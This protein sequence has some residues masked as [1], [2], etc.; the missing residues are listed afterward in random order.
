MDDAEFEHVSVST[1]ILRS[2]SKAIDFMVDRAWFDVVSLLAAITLPG[3]A[4]EP[5]K[6]YQRVIFVVFFSVMLFSLRE[7]I[8]QRNTHRRKE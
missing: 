1:Y 5:E 7:Y 6:A 4:S 8:Q 3:S 2:I